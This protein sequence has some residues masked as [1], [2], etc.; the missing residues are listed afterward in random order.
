MSGKSRTDEQ[1]LRKAGK[2][3]EETNMKLN[4]KTE[5]LK[6]MGHDSLNKIQIFNVWELGKDF[7]PISSATS[8]VN[9]KDNT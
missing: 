7:V 9:I 6:H 4:P 2:Q 5:K 8:T 1:R 3:K